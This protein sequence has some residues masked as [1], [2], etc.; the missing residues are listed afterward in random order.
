MSDSD[1]IVYETNPAM[2]RGRPILFVLLLISIIGW[3]ILILWYFFNKTTDVIVTKK[4]FIFVKG[5]LTKNRVEL[6]IDAIRTINVHQSLFQRIFDAGDIQI[7]TSGDVPEVI[8]NDIPN[9]LTLR[10]HLKV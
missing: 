8:V 2:F 9:P 3:P 6:R 4:N 7:Y 10:D 5:I 1:P